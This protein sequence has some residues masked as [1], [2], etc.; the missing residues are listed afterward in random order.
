MHRMEQPTI[1][2]AIAL[3]LVKLSQL[4][5]DLPEIAELDINP[6]IADPS[7]VIA[8]DARVRAQSGD[9]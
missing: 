6:L 9:F 3:T 5:A 4:V 2:Y 7:G 8:L 1:F